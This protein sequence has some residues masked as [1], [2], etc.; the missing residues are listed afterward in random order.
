ML[1]FYWRLFGYFENYC[2]MFVLYVGVNIFR[3]EFCYKCV[4]IK[5]LGVDGIN[6]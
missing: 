4:I 6:L 1:M 5:K 3:F 2:R